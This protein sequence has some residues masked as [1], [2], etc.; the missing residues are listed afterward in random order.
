MDKK[1]Y[2]IVIALIVNDQNQILIARRND[3][4]L[5]DAHDKWELVGGKIEYEETPEQA[6]VR[7]VKEE[8]GLEVEIVSLLP[9]LFVT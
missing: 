4:E 3:P 7:E 5:P 9:K 1:Q 6:V 2:P 8:T